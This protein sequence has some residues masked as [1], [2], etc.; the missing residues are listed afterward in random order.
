[1][2]WQELKANS[3]Y[4]IFSEYPHSIRRRGSTNPLSE[5]VCDKGY[6]HVHLWK[7][8][9][10]ETYRKHKL[11]AEQFIDNPNN[12]EEVDHINHNRSDNRIENLMWTT[13]RRNMNNRANSRH[14]QTLPEEAIKVPRY[15]DYIFDDL[16]Y[17]DNN[18]YV[19][20]G[21]DYVLKP[22]DGNRIRITDN[23][24]KLCSINFTKFINIY[25]A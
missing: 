6:I 15:L 2:S 3:N 7:N 14:I 21:I 22:R 5:T 12:Y 20:N 16:Y 25:V 4:E 24:K 17:Y 9:H 1:M 11:I 10:E 8:N 13:R 19:F 18:F 23:N